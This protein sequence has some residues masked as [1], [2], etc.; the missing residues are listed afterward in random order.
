M[1][2]ARFQLPPLQLTLQEGAALYLAARLLDRASDEP[3]PYVNRALAALAKVLPP[4]VGDEIQRL[5][6]E[7]PCQN[8]GSFA[9]VFEAVTLGWATGRVIHIW[10]RSANSENIHDYLFHPYMIE[11]SAVGYAAYAIGWAS[12]F[13]AVHTF[14]MERITRAELTD[15]T[16]TIPD[17]FDGVTLLRTAWGIAYAEPGA[18]LERV[19][20]KFSPNVTRRVKETQW[21]PSQKIEGTPDG[22]CILTVKVGHAWEMKPFI[23]GWGPDCEVLEPPW[24]RQEIAEEMRRAAAKYEEEQNGT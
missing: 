11:A 7:R 20:L 21:H 23:R 3:N 4:Q 1:E 5:V 9:D 13:D 6:S 18:P 14:K 8:E 16:F 10:H 24:L 15:E 19:W 12:W 22:G 2:G 17:D